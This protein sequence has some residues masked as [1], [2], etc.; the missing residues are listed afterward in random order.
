MN[1]NAAKLAFYLSGLAGIGY[2]A[3]SVSGDPILTTCLVLIARWI[4]PFS[5]TVGSL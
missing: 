4:K 5:T 2:V 1:T 3:W